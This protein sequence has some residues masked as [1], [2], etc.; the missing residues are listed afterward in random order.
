MN[1]P[2]IKYPW[3]D[4]GVDLDGQ[5]RINYFGQIVD[6]GAYEFLFNGTL[7]RTH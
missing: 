7:F 4:A 1:Y 2:S 5:P 3:M 6:M